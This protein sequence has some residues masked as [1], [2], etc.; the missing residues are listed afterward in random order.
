MLSHKSKYALAGAVGLEQGIGNG[1]L[2][3]SEILSANTFPTL[4]EL[5]LLD[6]R[7]TASMRSKKGKGG[8]YTLSEPPDSLSVGLVLRM[9]KDPLARVPCVSETAYREVR[10]MPRRE[11]LRH[12]PADEGRARCDRV[13]LIDHSP[14]CLDRSE[15]ANNGERVLNFSI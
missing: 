9:L 10:R 7:I 11:D 12:P 13:H 1:P 3:I 8:G 6:S 15:S 5:I 14:R 2:L 4:L